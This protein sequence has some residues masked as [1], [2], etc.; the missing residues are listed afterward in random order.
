MTITDANDINTVLHWAMGH[1]ARWPG[2]PP[3]TDEDAT[4]AA[5]GLAAKTYRALSGGLTPDQVELKRTA[6]ADTDPAC[7][8]CGCTEDKPCPGGCAW[9]E[10]PKLLGELCS[11]CEQL[12]GNAGLL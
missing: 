9:V 5:K 2:G 11:P 1:P 6:A 12:L 3:V 7:R 10:D 4:A 8:V